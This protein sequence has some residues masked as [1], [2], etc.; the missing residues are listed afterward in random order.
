M[1]KGYLLTALVAPEVKGL[2]P[3]LAHNKL[4]LVCDVARRWKCKH[5]AAKASG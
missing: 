3:N 4:V 5:T 2:E 1:E